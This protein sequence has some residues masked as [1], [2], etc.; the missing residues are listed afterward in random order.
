MNTIPTISPSTKKLFMWYKVKNLKSKNL[1]NS[2][3]GKKLGIHRTTVGEYLAMSEEE[4]RRSQSYQRDYPLLLGIA[5][6][7]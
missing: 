4:F 1:T 3:V 5:T 2:Q 7:E 6:F